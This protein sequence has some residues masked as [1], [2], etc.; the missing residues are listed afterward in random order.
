MTMTANG[1]QRQMVTSSADKQK[2]LRT[3]FEANKSAI[4]AVL[5]KHVTADRLMKIALSMTSKD[6][7]L[8]ACNPKSLF[9]SVVECA[10]LGLEPG[11]TLGEAY[12]VPFK[13]ECTLIVGYKGLIKL[14]R[15]SGEIKSIRARV[16][17][18]DD[19]FQVEY[20]LRETITHIPKLGADERKDEDIVAVYAI[21]EY[22]DGDPQFEVM[23]K[24]QVDAI[25]KR[26]ASAS[27]GPWVTDYAEMAKKTVIRRLSKVLP[28]SPEKSEAFQ[29]AIAHDNATDAGERSQ[30]IDVPFLGDDEESG[31]APILPIKQSRTDSL[32]GRVEANAKAS[33]AKVTHDADGVVV[34]VAK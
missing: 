4:M 30:V 23:T 9:R 32:V 31:D 26:S 19:E 33:G 11:G 17:Y 22:N 34:E 2:N 8:L 12:L 25:R 18:G 5:P 16:V 15:Q 20:G 1:G 28:L 6:A 13:D 10:A 27:S 14:A 21:A 29:K 24:G 7:K 3:L